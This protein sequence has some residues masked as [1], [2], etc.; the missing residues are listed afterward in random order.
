MIYKVGTTVKCNVRNSQFG[1]KLIN[2]DYEGNDN[3]E[4]MDFKIIAI[5]Y[6]YGDNVTP[7]YMLQ[8]PDDVGGYYVSKFYIA[9]YNLHP[10]LENKKFNETTHNY[11]LG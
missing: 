6:P 3:L 9:N 10:Y 4:V 5:S 8:V 7:L 1:K 2:Y 11:I